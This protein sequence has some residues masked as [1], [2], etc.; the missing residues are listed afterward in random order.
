MANKNNLNEN[1]FYK[2]IK[3]LWLTAG[4]TDLAVLILLFLAVD[5]AL[6]YPLLKNKL[7]AFIPLGEAGLLTWLKTY[8]PGNLPHTAWFYGLMVGLILLG[9]NTFVCSTTRVWALLNPSSRKKGWFLKL[10]PH[11]THYA[12]LVMVLGYLGS[13]TL[14][15]ALPGRALVPGGPALKLPQKLGTMSVTI[16]DPIVYNGTRLE[17]FDTWFLDPGFVLVFKDQNGTETRA[18]VAYN[19]P[20]HYAGYNFYLA[21]FYPKNAGGGMGSYRTVQLT[22]RKDPAATIYLVGIL[23]FAFG[24]ILYLLDL[25]QTRATTGKNREKP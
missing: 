11:I 23:I 25:Y 19:K 21:D 5:T 9:T 24:L 12:V 1:G 6:A 8:G 15:Q 17:F 18:K 7:F 10:G 20:A 16:E 13:Y 4:R 14:A 22:I 2:L 3:R